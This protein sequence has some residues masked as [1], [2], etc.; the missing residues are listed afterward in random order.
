MS[1]FHEQKVAKKKEIKYVYTNDQIEEIKKK[2]WEE[3]YAAGMHVTIGGVCAVLHNS[4]RFG[5]VRCS[6]VIE[7]L[8]WMLKS[9]GREGGMTVKQLEEA[10]FK[11]GG[12]KGV[13]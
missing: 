8:V 6:F 1:K 10:A 11:Y 12:V 13:L 7:R 9:I 4:L 5:R 3:G 2:A